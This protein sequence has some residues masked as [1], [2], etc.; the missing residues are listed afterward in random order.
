[1]NELAPCPSLPF[2]RSSHGLVSLWEMLSFRAQSFYEAICTI[3][4]LEMATR[5]PAFQDQLLG[6]ESR[7]TLLPPLDSLLDGCTLLELPLTAKSIVRLKQ[8]L[9]A[10][11][12]ISGRQLGTLV[13]DIIDRFRDEIDAMQLMI[14]PTEDQKFFDNPV[15]LFG[16]EVSERFGKAIPDLE[17]AGK[18]LALDRHTA[19]A[20][21]LMRALE[22]PLQIFARKLLPNDIRPNWDPIIRKIDDELK[23][24]HKER[25]IQGD[26]D[27]YANVS[28]HL[29]AIKLA[30]RNRINHLDEPVSGDKARDIFSAT[31]SLMI[32][33][34]ENLPEE[35]L[36]CGGQAD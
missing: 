16:E 18:C 11:D 1:M 36:P 9:Q 31:K 17:E 10:A 19:S 3:E 24:P 7:K 32:Y 33:L 34:A 14:I 6:P 4:R 8:R 25:A 2:R 20:F 30:W 15:I 26:V 13:N 28:A 5:V 29:H 21:H 23:L 27:F 22:V 35:L 12:E